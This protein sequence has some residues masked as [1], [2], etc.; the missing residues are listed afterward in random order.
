MKVKLNYLTYFSALAIFLAFN[1]FQYTV[2]D[3]KTPSN[4]EVIKFSHKFHIEMGAECEGCHS[5]ALE[6]TSLTGGLLPKMDDCAGCHD[7]TDNDQCTTCHYGENYQSFTEKTP[8]LYFNHKFHVTEQ[9]KKCTDCHQGLDKV[10]Y[11][12]ESAAAFPGM[13]NCYTCHNN[14]SVAANVCESC[15]ISTVNLLPK[16]HETVNFFDNHKFIALNDK[17][18]CIM[19]HDNSF[20]ES[21]HVSTISTDAANTKDD[22]YT[23]YSPHKFID[24]EKQ[25]QIT[26]VHDLNYRFT[27]GIDAKGISTECRTCHEVETFCAECHNVSGG[28]FALGGFVPSSHTAVNFATIGV[29]SGGGEHAILAKRDIESCASCHDTEGTDPNCIICHVDNDGIKGT[30]PKTHDTNFMRD[31]HGDWHS[32]QSAVCYNC[33]IDASAS[34]M[35]TA[36]IGFCG[37]CH[38]SNH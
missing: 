37:Y 27:H 12:I 32:S 20:C 34:P 24:N 7:V 17:E 10:E 31:E 15:H 33:H 4:K 5:G 36:G 38:G 30:N 35:G 8:G 6:S 1:A 22:F 13:E 23:P 3:E 21:C 11:S 26:R 14:Q 18:N 9:N 28:D 19:C 29:G 2:G 16:N 25:Q